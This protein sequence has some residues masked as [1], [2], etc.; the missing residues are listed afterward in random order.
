MLAEPVLAEKVPVVEPAATVTEAGTV[1]AAGAVLAR[2]TLEPP[3]GAAFESVTVQVV[4]AF[5]ARLAAAHCNDETVIV[6]GAT[7]DRVAD[8]ED[9]LREAVTVAD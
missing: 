8:C 4:E 2:A 1:K 6:V 5:G 3:A 7:S 9:P